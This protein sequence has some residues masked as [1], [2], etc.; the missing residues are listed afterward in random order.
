MWFG[1]CFFSVLK[2]LIASRSFSCPALVALALV[3]AV[4]A[5]LVLLLYDTI[6]GDPLYPKP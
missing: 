3:V 4:V 6:Q 2:Y 5:A 1:C